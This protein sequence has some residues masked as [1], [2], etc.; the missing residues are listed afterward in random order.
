VTQLIDTEP[1]HPFRGNGKRIQALVHDIE[2]AA[3]EHGVDPYLLASMAWHETRFLNDR[4]GKLGEQGVIQ[5]HGVAARGCSFDSD[6][7]SLQCGA[8]WLRRQIGKC[9]GVPSGLHAYAT[10]GGRCKMVKGTRAYRAVHR[11]LKLADKLRGSND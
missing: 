11:R 6:L 10:K 1:G 9:G 2:T 3:V 8:K 5:V 7:G 4:R